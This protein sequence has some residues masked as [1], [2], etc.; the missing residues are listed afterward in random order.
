M[1]GELY[2][3]AHEIHKSPGYRVSVLRG[4][5]HIH[6]LVHGSCVLDSGT[7]GRSRKL[8]GAKGARGA[9]HNARANSSC[10]PSCARRSPARPLGRA[11]HLRAKHARSVFRAG[12]RRGAGPSVS[13]GIVETRGPG[14][15][16]GSD[17]QIGAAARYCGAAVALSG[18][19]AGGV[20][21]LR[22]RYARN[23]RS[24]HRRHQRVH[25]ASDDAG[26]S[27]LAG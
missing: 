14:P 8:A 24:V 25:S 12:I 27:G 22:A 18:L 5:P 1:P 2:T 10:W 17:G 9:F 3:P 19:D 4:V 13:D 21:E 20:H 11:A 7:Q 16:R 6:S 26:R 23:P 15:A